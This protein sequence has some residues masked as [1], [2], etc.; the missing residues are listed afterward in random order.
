MRELAFEV[1]GEGPVLLFTHGWMMS[2]RVWAGQ[3]PLAKHFKVVT[4]DLPQHGESQGGTDKIGLSE[5]AESLHQLISELKLENICYIGWSLGMTVFW[6]YCELYGSKPFASI[7]NV[8]ML[9][10]MDPKEAMVEGVEISMRRDQMRAMRKFAHRVFPHSSEAAMASLEKSFG[11]TPIESALGLY[12]EMAAGDFRQVAAALTQP[13][14]L[15]LGREGFF[16]GR[17]D[18]LLKLLPAV[19]LCWFDNAG[20]APFWDRPEEFNQVVRDFALIPCG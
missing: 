18:E 12:R 2:R 7:V 14:L 1:S 15:C 4:W 20:H 6:R 13:Q 19:T 10:I 9:P 5:C 17:D 8:E 3:G 16:R 11:M